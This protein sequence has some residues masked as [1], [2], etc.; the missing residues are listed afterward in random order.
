MRVKVETGGVEKRRIAFL[1]LDVVLYVRVEHAVTDVGGAAPT[2][3]GSEVVVAEVVVFDGYSHCSSKQQNTLRAS[4]ELIVFHE[5]LGLDQ[6]GAVSRCANPQPGDAVGLD[7]E[8]AGLNP[9][10]GDS[11]CVHPSGEG[12]VGQRDAPSPVQK[13]GWA[14]QGVDSESGIRAQQ[15]WSAQDVVVACGEGYLGDEQ[16]GDIGGLEERKGSVLGIADHTGRSGVGGREDGTGEAVEEFDGGGEPKVSLQHQLDGA[17]GRVF[18]PRV[19]VS[20]PGHLD[21]DDVGGAR[22]GCRHKN[23]M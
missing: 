9:G 4:L 6:V 14:G 19:E 8:G 15:F 2:L 21:G 7:L 22:T 13:D 3:N 10:L 18:E 12:Q 23:D 20:Q 5:D 1:E 11:K 17:R 16:V